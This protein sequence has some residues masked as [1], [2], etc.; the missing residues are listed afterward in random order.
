MNPQGEL[1]NMLKIQDLN[2]FRII[3]SS[4]ESY[5]MKVN[6]KINITFNNE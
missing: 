5:M 4:F 6:K 3:M 2:S 1:L